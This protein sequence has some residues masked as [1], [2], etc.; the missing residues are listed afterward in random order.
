MG[1]RRRRRK[2]TSAAVYVPVAALLILFLTMFGTSVFLKVTDIRVMDI[3]A[4]GTAQYSSKEIIKASGI[5]QGD[6]ILLVDTIGVQLRICTAL[7]YI[8]E[9]AVTRSMPNTIVIEVGYSTPLAMLEWQG[10]IVIIDSAGRVL[11][12]VGTAPSGLIEIRGLEPLDATDGIVLRVDTSGATQRSSMTEILAAIEM[13]GI[14]DK[15]S[16]LDVA[17]IAKIS[18][19]YMK[20]FNVL[21][22]G[23]ED[24]KS[25]LDK[26]AEEVSKIEAMTQPTDQGTFNMSQKPWRWEPNQFG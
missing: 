8:R 1:E 5:V 22:G 21:L 25:K 2:S 4:K 13:A 19:G 23:S 24:V 20:R 15:I 11:Q 14:Q 7:P 26:L 12:H 6:N 3:S 17:N 10:E 16:Y 18:F 9:V